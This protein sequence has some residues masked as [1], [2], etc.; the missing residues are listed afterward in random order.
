MLIL[1]KAELIYTTGSSF[2]DAVRYFNP[3]IKIVSVDGR[4]IGR[5]KNN[6]PIPKKA[7]LD[8]LSRSL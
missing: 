4:R 1:A 8:K 2:V 3:Q 7:L 6:I 5:G